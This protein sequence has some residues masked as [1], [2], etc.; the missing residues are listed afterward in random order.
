MAVPKTYDRDQVASVLKNI[1]KVY[2]TSLDSTEKKYTSLL[3]S[4]DKEIAV[5][6]EENGELKSALSEVSALLNLYKLQTNSKL[7]SLKEENARLSHVI[8]AYEKLLRGDNKVMFN[9]K[10]KAVT[11]SYDDG[12]T[13]DRRLIRLLDKY[14]LKCTFNISSGLFSHASPIVVN[15]VTV[16]HVR[17]PK[18]EIKSLYE[19]HEVA[20][21]GITHPCL[22]NLTD[23]EIIHEVEDDRIALSEIVGYDVVGM[24]YPFGTGSMNDHVADLIAKNTGVRYSRTTTSTHAFEPQTELLKFNPTIHQHGEMDRMF[25]LAKEF[26]EMKPDSPK[27]FYI[28][29]HSYEID[30]RDDWDRLEEF[31][32]LISGHDDIFYGTNKDVLL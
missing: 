21:H 5:L 31:F 12:V 23:E 29:G 25:E 32:A 14:G 6:S 10:M 13:Q 7:S 26:V 30:A 15:G 24:A 28:W 11:F 4:R 1:E 19:G 3:A 2:R 27:I 18:E 8:S 16:P 17:F 22:K 9:G 20:V